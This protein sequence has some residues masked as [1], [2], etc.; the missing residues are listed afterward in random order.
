MKPFGYLHAMNSDAPM[1]SRRTEM[2]WRRRTKNVGGYW[3]KVVT[4]KVVGFWIMGMGKI[5][6]GEKDVV[7]SWYGDRATKS[8]ATPIWRIR[9]YAIRKPKST[10]ASVK[11]ER[12]PIVFGL[13]TVWP[14]AHFEPLNFVV[15]MIVNCERCSK[16]HYCDPG[17]KR[18]SKTLIRELN[19]CFRDGAACHIVVV[20]IFC[21]VV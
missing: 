16:R 20:V 6:K 1:K 8:A 21:A 17:D 3:S 15:T 12:Q 10:F 2:G 14:E 18:I 9:Y 5:G 19:E 13:M 11:V 4:T 7:N